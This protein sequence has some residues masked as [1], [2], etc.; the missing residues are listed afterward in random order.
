MD[1]WKNLPLAVAA[2]VQVSILFGINFMKDPPATAVEPR[3]RPRLGRLSFF[4]LRNAKAFIR[5]QAMY[6]SLPLFIKFSLTRPPAVTDRQK[7]QS[8]TLVV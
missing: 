4:E 7:Q 8:C 1:F 3:D 6:P 5:R 2:V